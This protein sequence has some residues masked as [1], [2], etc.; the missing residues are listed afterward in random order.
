M[1]TISSSSLSQA[2]TGNAAKAV[3]SYLDTKLQTGKKVETAAG[4][5]PRQDNASFSLEGILAAEGYNRHG[6]KCTRKEDGSYDISFRNIAYVYGAAER[7]TL[8]VDGK[9]VSISEKVRQQL[10]KAADSIYQKQE[11]QIKSAMALHDAQVYDRQGKAMM[12]AKKKELDAY[13]IATRMSHGNLVSHKEE[14]LLLKTDPTLY[15][16][17]KLSQHMAKEHKKDQQRLR[18]ET[19][20]EAAEEQL[21]DPMEHL[22]EYHVDVKA[23]ISGGDLEIISI[24]ET[25]EIG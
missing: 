11:K 23:D 5:Q 6:V 13:K 3:S 14:S 7:G 10:K 21:E 17:A 1:A 25:E 15:F 4:T 9:E 2:A 16:M 24:S 22:S 20:R 19:K 18:E 8:E 12:E